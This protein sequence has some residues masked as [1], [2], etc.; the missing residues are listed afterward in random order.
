MRWQPQA[1]GRVSPIWG[2]ISRQYVGTTRHISGDSGVAAL[3]SHIVVASL[4]A[5][6]AMAPVAPEAG[7]IL[8]LAAG[9]VAI[10]LLRGGDQNAIQ[11]PS[12]W[13]PLLGLVFLGLAYTLS[14]GAAGL[15]GLMFV[16]PLAATLLLIAAA[17]RSDLQ[18]A[19]VGLLALCGVAGSAAIAIAEF[20]TT[21]TPRVGIWVANP[22]HF[23]DLS[24]SV[25]FLALVGTVLGRS[26]DRWLFIATPLLATVAVLLSGTRGAVVALAIMAGTAVITSVAVGLITL[27][28]LAIGVVVL[29]AVLPAAWFAGIGQTS[30]V[31]RV[32][33]DVAD[34]FRTGLPTD[35]S[36]VLRL[37]M[38]E[39]GLNAFLASPLYGHGPFAFVE[40]AA[41]RA[42]TPFEGAPHLHN[43]LADFAASG[44]I[45]GLAAYMLFLWAPL[46]EALRAPNTSHRAGLVIVSSTLVVGYFVMGLTNAMFGIL[47]LTVFY[48]AATLVVALLAQNGERP[49]R[50]RPSEGSDGSPQLAPVP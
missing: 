50:E 10:L 35:E 27:R 3:R 47:N 7:N 29:A 28:K 43:D 25:A 19:L 11:R 8:F 37:Q 45:L 39:G 5:A 4:V 26:L 48:A 15:V 23:A 14:S 49:E 30:G 21:G 12:V 38:Y 17:R 36:T 24:L 16:V 44:G 6:L 18:P 34:V 20:T 42:S 31:Q 13:M 40:A 22:I 1:Q 2:S 9:A 33:A 32:V 46:V 41:S